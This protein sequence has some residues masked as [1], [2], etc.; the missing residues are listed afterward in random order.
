MPGNLYWNTALHGDLPYLESF[1][2]C[3]RSEIKPLA[4]ARPTRRQIIRSMNGRHKMRNSSGHLDDIDLA[5]LVRMELECDIASVGGPAGTASCSMQGRNLVAV[6]FLNLAS[7][8]IPK[9]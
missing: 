8:Q 4:V 2:A 7:P 3:F 1:R 6:S 5:V 9:T